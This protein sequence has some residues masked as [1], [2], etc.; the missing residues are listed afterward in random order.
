MVCLTSA[1]DSLYLALSCT[2]D[3]YT[4][5]AN[6][7]AFP[8]RANYASLYDTAMSSP[9][10]KFAK[11]SA[12]HPD[13]NRNAFSSPLLAPSRHATKSRFSSR[14]PPLNTMLRHAEASPP[15]DP[16]FSPG[17]SHTVPRISPRQRTSLCSPNVDPTSPFSTVV[18]LFARQRPPPI[19]RDPYDTPSSPDTSWSTLPTS[20]K[21]GTKPSQ[22]GKTTTVNFR[23]PLATAA[24]AQPEPDAKRRRISY[25]PPP[26]TQD[27]T[28]RRPS[29][30][31]I[32]DIPA[33]W[34]V[35]RVLPSQIPERFMREARPADQSTST[36]TAKHCSPSQTTGGLSSTRDRIH[37]YPSPPH[38][39]SSPSPTPFFENRQ[40]SA[41]QGLSDTDSPSKATSARTDSYRSQLV[42]ARNSLPSPPRSDPP[43]DSHSGDSEDPCGMGQLSIP[44]DSGEL[45]DRYPKMRMAV[46][47]VHG[48]THII[49]SNILLTT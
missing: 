29:Q 12:S 42:P 9:M 13:V 38:R 5:R 39:G 24:K 8:A 10:R 25:L 35:T 40:V 1:S 17:I 37:G 15:P 45:E 7:R 19:Q 26:R 6:Y 18:H 23:L 16:T 14:I 44:F 36:Y 30:E 47:E 4:A 3:G 46:A 28:R 21:R 22:W 2:S 11:T 32:S 43:S 41:A 31:A 49:K 20:K 48:I 27:R 33:V 34:K